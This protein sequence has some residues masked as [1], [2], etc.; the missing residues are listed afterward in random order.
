MDL[1]LKQTSDSVS[2]QTVVDPKGNFYFKCY[3][4]LLVFVCN[5]LLVFSYHMN[6]KIKPI[7]LEPITNLIIIDHLFN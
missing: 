4:V 1:K 7:K 6:L 3:D 2:G 5:L